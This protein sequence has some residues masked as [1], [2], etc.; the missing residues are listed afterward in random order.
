MNDFKQVACWHL[1]RKAEKDNIAC[2]MLVLASLCTAG[3]SMVVTLCF[4]HVT[5]GQTSTLIHLIMYLQRAL[6]KA[7]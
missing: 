1:Y 7:E 4:Y 2:T 3:A 5:S 6:L